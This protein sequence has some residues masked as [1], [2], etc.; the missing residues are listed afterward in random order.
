MGTVTAIL[1]A[2]YFGAALYAGFSPS[3]DPQRGMAQG[4]IILVALVLS[5]LAA[6]LYVGMTR[7][8]RWLVRALFA[9]AVFPALSLVA[10][11]IY[12]LA[13]RAH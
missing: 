9:L 7:R 5:V 13:H 10:Q 4:F 6:A 2:G 1:L 3:T 8:H 12:L 11:G